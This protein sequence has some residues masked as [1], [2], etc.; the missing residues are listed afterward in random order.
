MPR[1]PA[2]SASA[3]LMLHNMTENDMEVVMDFLHCAIELLLMLQNEVGSGFKDF[4]HIVMTPAVG[5]VSMQQV[6]NLCKEQVN[7]ATL[8]KMH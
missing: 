7:P 8:A 6:I 1:Y 5:K 3:A 4:V 2:V